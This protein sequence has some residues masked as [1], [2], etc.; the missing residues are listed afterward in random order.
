MKKYFVI[1]AASLMILSCNKQ[2]DNALKSADKEYILKTANDF[3]AKKKWADAIALY[4]RLPNLVA[5]TDD[6]PEVVFKTA[7]AIFIV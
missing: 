7:F 5:G 1:A 2:L 3:Y 6:A 4:E